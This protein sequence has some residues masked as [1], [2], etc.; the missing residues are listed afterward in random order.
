MPLLNVRDYWPGVGLVYS[1]IFCLPDF[2]LEV[3]IDDTQ[4]MML[5]K[6]SCRDPVFGVCK[7]QVSIDRVCDI[8]LVLPGIWPCCHANFYLP[9]FCLRCA[10]TER[11]TSSLKTA[12]FPFSNLGSGKAPAHS[13]LLPPRP[14]PPSQSPPSLPPPPTPLPPLSPSDNLSKCLLFSRISSRVHATL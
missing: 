10:W 2:W 1:A 14:P 9:Y 11:V 4:L 3:C 7:P 8:R 13:D 6:R 5:C 12:G